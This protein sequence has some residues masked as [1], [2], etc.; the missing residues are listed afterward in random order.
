MLNQRITNIS[1]ILLVRIHAHPTTNV[2]LGGFMLTR[3][4]MFLAIVHFPLRSTINP[5]ERHIQGKGS[6]AIS[7]K[8]PSRSK[9]AVDITRKGQQKVVRMYVCIIQ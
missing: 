9:F 8:S 7:H 5:L 2:I 1:W 3:K 4:Q 6:S